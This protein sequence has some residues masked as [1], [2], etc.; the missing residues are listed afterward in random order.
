MKALAKLKRMYYNPQTATDIIMLIYPVIA[1]HML[2]VMIDLGGVQKVAP[3]KMICSS[4][5]QSI[6]EGDG[7]SFVR[8][9]QLN[10]HPELNL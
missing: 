9:F 10:D 2:L 1:Q 8:I 7:L 6:S 4:V 5:G 3:V